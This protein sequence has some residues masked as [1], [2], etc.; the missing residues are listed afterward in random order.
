M[1]RATS[2]AAEADTS[3]AVRGRSAR[4]TATSGAGCAPRRASIDVAVPQVRGAGEPFRSSLMSFLDGNSEVL[5]SAGH[6]DVCPRPVHPGCG[7]RV[8]RRDRRAADL[9]ER[10]QRDHR[11]VVG[12]LPGLHRPGLVRDRGGVPVRR[13]GVRGAAPARREGGAAGGAG[14]STPT[15]A[16]TCCTWPSATRSPRRAGPSSSA[17]CSSAGC[18]C[19]PRSPP[20]A[21]PG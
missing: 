13:C 7:G 9:Q 4:A 14:A 17:P 10:G 15:G 20:T 11:P 18:G 1:S 2:S 3:A 5:D 6:R 21:R 19:R 12:G 16:S 8:P